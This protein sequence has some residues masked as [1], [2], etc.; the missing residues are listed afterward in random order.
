MAQ[1]NHTSGE[2]NSPRL[3]AKNPDSSRYG[4]GISFARDALVHLNAI[5]CSVAVVLWFSERPD[6]PGSHPNRRAGTCHDAPRPAR[7]DQTT[8]PKNV[9]F[10]WLKLQSPSAYCSVPSRQAVVRSTL[11]EPTQTS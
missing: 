3:S 11:F 4:G 2:E 5:G 6:P 7:H 1:A 9:S 10:D 8:V